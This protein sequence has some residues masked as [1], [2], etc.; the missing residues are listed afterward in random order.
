MY[1]NYLLYR[2]FIIKSTGLLL[3]IAL[4]FDFVQINGRTPDPEGMTFEKYTGIKTGAYYTKF[5]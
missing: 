3:V 4:L 2:G 5:A 1:N